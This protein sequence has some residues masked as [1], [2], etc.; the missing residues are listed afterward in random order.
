MGMN[1]EPYR[2]PDGTIDILKAWREEVKPT[3]KDEK[4]GRLFL[5]LVEQ[6]QPINSRQAAAIALA[7]ADTL[8]ILKNGD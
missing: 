2:R 1:W 4:V 3:Y 7:G 8:V 5:I 6:Y